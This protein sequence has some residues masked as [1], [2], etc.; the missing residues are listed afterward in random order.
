[1]RHR[2]A[3]EWNNESCQWE[4]EIQKYL[5][6]I[7][8]EENEISEWESLPGDDMA[9]Q[10]ETFDEATACSIAAFLQATT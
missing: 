9:G 6:E 2:I 1:M 5:G 8:D 10:N 4:W 7:P 3:L